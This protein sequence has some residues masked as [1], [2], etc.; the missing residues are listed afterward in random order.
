MCAAAPVA[1]PSVSESLTLAVVVCVNSHDKY[2]GDKNMVVVPGGHNSPRPQF[3]MDSI[4]IFLRTAMRIP[5][6]VR[7]LRLRRLT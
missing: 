2:A 4:G 3:C 6:E 1:P 5:T 7:R